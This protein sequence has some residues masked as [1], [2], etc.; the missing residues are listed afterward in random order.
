M[1]D[2]QIVRMNATFRAEFRHRKDSQLHKVWAYEPIPVSIRTIDAASAPI[3]HSLPWQDGLLAWRMVDGVLMRPM[4]DDDGSACGPDALGQHTES[5]R[6]FPWFLSGYPMD[7]PES[8]PSHGVP[9]GLADLKRT[10]SLSDIEAGKAAHT[11]GEFW[12]W[13][14]HERDAAQQRVEHSAANDLAIIDGV[15]HKRVL[16][17]CIRVGV[18]Y[19][20][21]GERKILLRPWLPEWPPLEGRAELIAYAFFGL[22]ELETAVAFADHLRD[23]HDWIGAGRIDV[24][25]RL[26]AATSSPAEPA[27]MVRTT[28]MALAMQSHQ[29]Q[30]SSSDS[31]STITATTLLEN[32]TRCPPAGEPNV[33]HEEAY[34]LY[35]RLSTDPGVEQRHERL[36][37]MLLAADAFRS[38][39]AMARDLSGIRL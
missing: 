18:T 7:H 39:M 34:G 10:K 6:I 4:L 8:V 38:E 29:S 32:A 31:L 5:S 11:S 27:D 1:P 21:P 28:V 24:D 17:P 16:P 36:G 25:E 20:L 37:R 3:V 2:S 13:V 30:Y 35:L 23:A 26:R 33:S 22:D 12:K 9:K 15:L 14:H 19:G